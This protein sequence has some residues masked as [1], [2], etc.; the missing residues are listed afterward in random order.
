MQRDFDRWRHNQLWLADI[1]EHRTIEVKLYVCVVRHL[2]SERI[3]GFSIFGRMKAGIT[4]EAFNN[5]AVR[6]GNAT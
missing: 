1:S 3:V 4:V 5:A 6:H 2:F